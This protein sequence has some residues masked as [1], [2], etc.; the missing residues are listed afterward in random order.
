MNLNERAMS[1]LLMYL[2]VTFIAALL[3]SNVI[4]NHMLLFFGRTID[5]GALTFPITY[6]ISD[7]ISEVYGYKWSR[8]VAWTSLAINAFFALIII[9]IVRLPQPDWYEGNYFA[10]ALA[11]SWRIVVASL[12][13]YCIGDLADDRIFRRLRMHNRKKFGGKENMRGFAFR[14]LLSSLIGH[15]LDTN[16]FI[17]IAFAFIV[18]WDELPGM[19]IIGISIKW[20]YEWAV[21]PITYRVT[22]WVAKKEDE[23]ENSRN[24]QQ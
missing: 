10:T 2:S 15:I 18:P 9:I 3:I 4:A 24:G 13:A 22:K 17:F 1:P 5:A 12:V 16:I 7:V 8:R 21:I 20:T 6:I 11:N 14:A 23:Y 19:I